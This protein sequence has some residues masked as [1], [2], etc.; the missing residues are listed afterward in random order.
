[1]I[2]SAS[3]RDLLLM[4]AVTELHVTG[5]HQRAVTGSFSQSAWTRY[6]NPHTRPHISARQQIYRCNK[7]AAI[8]ALASDHQSDQLRLHRVNIVV[9]PLFRSGGTAGCRQGDGCLLV[10]AAHPG[11]APILNRRMSSP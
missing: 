8:P 6:A 9:G 10:A 1:M 7:M 3:A 11:S 2:A 4:S 5:G